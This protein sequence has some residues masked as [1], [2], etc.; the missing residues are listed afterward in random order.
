[1]LKRLDEKA[2]STGEGARDAGL[3]PGKVMPCP[4]VGKQATAVLWALCT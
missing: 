3:H 1:M 4:S 2:D